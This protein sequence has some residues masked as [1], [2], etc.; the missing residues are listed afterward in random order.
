MRYILVGILLFSLTLFAVDGVPES[1]RAKS[2]NSNEDLFLADSSNL[3][4]SVQGLGVAPMYATSP[5][6]AY[7]LA[8]RAATVEAYRLI[9]ERVKGV[10]VEGED[11]IKNMVVKRTIARAYVS[12]MVQNATVVETTFKDGVCEVEMEVM[13]YHK[14]FKQ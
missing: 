4:V 6:Q 11:I 13:L 9:A 1:E 10:R 7:A 8:K 5:G 2:Q 14:Q 12:A 3:R